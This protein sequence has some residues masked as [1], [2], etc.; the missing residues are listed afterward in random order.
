[1]MM[2]T[3]SYDNKKA[4]SNSHKERQRY[5]RPIRVDELL[6]DMGFLNKGKGVSR[7]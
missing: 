1:M 4:K 5:N 3:L 7:V 6:N 2:K